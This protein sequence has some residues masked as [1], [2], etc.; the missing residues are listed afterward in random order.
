[1]KPVKNFELLMII[2]QL[3]M[4]SSSIEFFANLIQKKLSIVYKRAF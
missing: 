1:M 2:N 3:L 4:E